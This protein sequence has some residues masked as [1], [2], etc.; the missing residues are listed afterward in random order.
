MVKS[1]VLV[2]DEIPERTSFVKRHMT[3]R[4]IFPTYWSSY[5]GKTWGLATTIEYKPGERLTPGGCGLS[6]GSWAMWQHASLTHGE[7]D[8]PILFFEDDA[9]IPVGFQDTLEN[10]T[11]ELASFIPDWGLVFLGL[12]DRPESVSSKVT[13]R[14]NDRLVKMVD[15][16]GTHALLIRRYALSVL[17]RKMRELNRLL[18]Q[19]LYESVLKPG[20]LEWC[21][22]VPSIVSQRTY[23]SFGGGPEWPTSV[24]SQKPNP[25]QEHR[26]LPHWWKWRTP[27]R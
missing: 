17:L 8:E 2:C 7:P 18:D 12:A 4:G 22:V 16:F 13:K 27:T 5:H 15:P 21:A 24:G 26:G 6:L 9:V 14:I 3:E 20:F 23:D 11:K 25:V 10:L 19:Q 1:F